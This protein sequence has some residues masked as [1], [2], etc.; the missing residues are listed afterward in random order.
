MSG[1]KILK[2]S[3]PVSVGSEVIAELS[4]REPKFSDYIAIG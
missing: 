4:F 3:D 1:P 2:L